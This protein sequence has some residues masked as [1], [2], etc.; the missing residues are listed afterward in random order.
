[1]LPGV[2]HLFWL[3]HDE[4]RFEAERSKL[5]SDYISSLPEERRAAAWAMQQKIDQARKTLSG[6]KLLAWMVGEAVELQA[7]VVD[8]FNHIHSTVKDLKKSLDDVSRLL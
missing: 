5:I 2:A 1:M 8:Q 4:V 7:N 3:R 6:D